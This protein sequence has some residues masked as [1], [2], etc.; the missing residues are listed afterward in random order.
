M[1]AVTWCRAQLQQL[2]QVCCVHCSL[3]AGQSAESSL[4]SSWMQDGI[5]KVV[6]LRG[7]SAYV[8]I[9]VNKGAIT[10]SSVCTPY[11]VA[12]CPPPP[13]RG[14]A[15]MASSEMF[16]KQVQKVHM[17]MSPAVNMF[18]INFTVTTS[19]IRLSAPKQFLP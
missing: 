6:R 19:S 12:T 15:N 10:F 13:K 9:W 4:L 8:G 14:A 7:S 1:C 18:T 2:D 3:C 11:S 16:L 17:L 5:V